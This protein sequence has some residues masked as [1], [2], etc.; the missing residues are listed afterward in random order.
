MPR[1]RL[2][3]EEWKKRDE[4][5]RS[6][7]QKNP[8]LPIA[9]A[10]AQCTKKFGEPVGY[11][12]L[13]AIRTAYRTINGIKPPPV[14]RRRRHEA[15]SLSTAS[16]EAT[17]DKLRRGLGQRLSPQKNSLTLAVGRLLVTPGSRLY[18]PKFAKEMEDA[19]PW[20]FRGKREVL[21]NMARSGKARPNKRSKDDIE[22]GLGQQL[23]TL[24]TRSGTSYDEEFD[25]EIRALRPDWFRRS[26]GDGWEQSDETDD[27]KH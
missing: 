12:R 17:K 22:R 1:K 4:F 19:P 13:I 5:A 2:T 18:D 15:E 11:T 26:G 24:V 27:T 10:D 23:C 6:L 14:T 3:P 8:F 25:R 21:L 16:I 7:F 20:F 9:E